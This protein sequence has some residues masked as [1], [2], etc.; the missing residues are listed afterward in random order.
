MVWRAF[1][2]SGASVPDPIEENFPTHYTSPRDDADRTD[3][4]VTMSSKDHRAEILLASVKNA[5]SPVL[6][7]FYFFNF[8]L[9]RSEEA[10]DER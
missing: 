1:S 4:P 2:L 7:S 10:R 3:G 8:I 9:S 6:P 5:V